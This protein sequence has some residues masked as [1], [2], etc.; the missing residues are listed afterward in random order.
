MSHGRRWLETSELRIGLGCMRLPADGDVAADTIA[1]AAAAGI[2]IF[3]TA[4]AYGGD[5]ASSGQN[6]RLV[7]RSL[8]SCGAGARARIV[9]KGGMTRAGTAWIPDGRAKSIA[10]DCEASLI[11]LDGMAIDMYLLHAPDAR[12]AW[13]TS[14]RA[15][16]RLLDER[17]VAH[18]GLSNIT[19]RQLEEAVDAVDITAVEVALSALDDSAIRSGLVELCAERGIAVIAH[20]PLG[21]P[22][23]A[24][25]LARRSDLVDIAHTRDATPQEVALAWL[26]D[27]SPMVVPIP[28]ATRPETA[29]SAARAATLKI[30][31]DDRTVLAATFGWQPRSLAAD[32]PAGDADVVLVMGV[33][34][35]G[36]SRHA[37]E[38]VVRGYARLNRDE[39]GGSLRQLSDALG[40]ALA[41]GELHVV[42]DNTYLTRA[43]RSHLI[44]QAARHGVAVRCVWIDTPLA[45]AQVNLVQRLID[46]FGALPGPDQMAAVARTEPGLLTPTR[47]MRAFRELEPPTTG[48]GFASVERIAFERTSREVREHAI[49]KPRAVFVAAAA[50]THP[51]WED[52]IASGKPDAPHLLFD[53]RPGAPAD[54]LDADVTRLGAVV[55]GSVTGGLCA[56]PGGAPVCWCRPPL[57][58]LLVAFARQHDVDLDRTTLIGTSAAHRT[59]AAT[60]GAQ[61]R[62]G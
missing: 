22:R 36:K 37:D 3:D 43:V 16:G 33:P 19:R 31:D 51:G 20:S 49:A 29:R 12:T 59:L 15:L 18:V 46:R 57:P 26:L 8:H 9:T 11:A 48:E 21:G 32:S 52:V 38:F 2:T 62:A 25:A 60:L 35:A 17:L 50:M 6:E 4:H 44:E 28:G 14:V 30:T 10:A 58:G 40:D 39:R 41:S 34:G 1:T 47:Q 23:R 54:A 7:A 53:W 5:D 56:H 24:R 61:Y 27:I 13:P 42:L 55:T 45:Q